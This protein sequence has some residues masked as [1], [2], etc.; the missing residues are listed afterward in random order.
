M[1][2]SQLYTALAT[3]P[4]NATPHSYR[5]EFPDEPGEV[6]EFLAFD[7]YQALVRAKRRSGA[8]A[9]ELWRDGRKICSLQLLPHG[10]WEVLPASK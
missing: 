1:A 7:A 4:Q 2:Q 10:V 9:S 5:L 6:E 8:R 3:E